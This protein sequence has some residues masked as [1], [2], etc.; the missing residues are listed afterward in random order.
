MP[1]PLYKLA[2]RIKHLKDQAQLLNIPNQLA[3]EDAKDD[4]FIRSPSEDKHEFNFILNEEIE[5]QGSQIIELSMFESFEQPFETFYGRFI[6]NWSELE[7]DDEVQI[8]EPHQIQLTIRQPR[9]D[10]TGKQE[11]E[12]PDTGGHA[13]WANWDER[14]YNIV[15]IKSIRVNHNQGDFYPELGEQSNVPSHSEFEWWGVPDYQYR[16]MIPGIGKDED[17]ENWKPFTQKQFKEKTYTEIFEEIQKRL[18]VKFEKDDPKYVMETLNRVPKNDPLI[19]P[20][21]TPLLSILDQLVFNTWYSMDKY[22]THQIPYYLLSNGYLQYRMQYSENTP[23]QS[24][25]V[26]LGNYYVKGTNYENLQE[27]IDDYIGYKRFIFETFTFVSSSRQGLLGTYSNRNPMNLHYDTDEQEIPMKYKP[28]LW[29]NNQ[30]PERFNKEHIFEKYEDYWEFDQYYIDDEYFLENRMGKIYN[31]QLSYPFF[32]SDKIRVSTSLQMD[33]DILDGLRLNTPLQLHFKDSQYVN[34]NE[35]EDLITQTGDDPVTQV[36]FSRLHVIFP[37]IHSYLIQMDF[38]I[39]GK[40]NLYKEDKSEEFPEHL[41]EHD[42]ENK[43]YLGK[44]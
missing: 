18:D 38:A 37:Q 34:T 12:S 19:F 40:H 5:V 26:L 42:K 39:T 20:A 14:T 8:L 2:E 22:E 36:V 28:T 13:D 21:N 11:T 35:D 27:R 9:Y 16:S 3:G 44:E 41:S 1:L 4:I 31:H 17:D 30:E 23:G 24:Y 25:P 7:D 15:I 32:G 10:D 43:A 33:H 6:L 29:M